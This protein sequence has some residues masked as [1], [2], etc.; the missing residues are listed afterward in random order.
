MS[1]WAVIGAAASGVLSTM[2]VGHRW[3]VKSYLRELVPNGGS[4]MA[5]RIGRIEDNQK[6]LHERIDAIYDHLITNK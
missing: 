1:E 6:R 3:L 4:S 5:D 2:F